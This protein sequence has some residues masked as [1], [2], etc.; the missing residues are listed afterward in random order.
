M[1]Q[2]RGVFDVLERGWLRALDLIMTPTLGTP[3]K[4]LEKFTFT[5]DYANDSL[6]S[7]TMSKYGKVSLSLDT[8]RGDLCQMIRR[9]IELDTTLPRLPGKKPF[10]FRCS[11]LQDV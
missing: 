10:G 11:P 5:F 9:I 3:L 2:E 6:Q 4:V 1:A 8:I 7:I